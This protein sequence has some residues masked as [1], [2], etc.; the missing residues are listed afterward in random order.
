M[1]ACSDSV[2]NEHDRSIKPWRVLHACETVGSVA[3]LAEAQSAVG[4]IPQMLSREYWAAADA[5]NRFSLMTA[6]NDVRDWRHALNEAEALNS[7]QIVHAHS[8]TSAMAGVRGTLPVVYDFAATLE[9]VAS[10]QPNSGTWL[11]RSLRVAEQFALSRASA[12]V[13][14]CNAMKDVATQRGAAAENIFMI[15]DPI[16]ITTPLPEMT[17]AEEHGIDL[18]RD[19]VMFAAPDV[20]SVTTVLQAFASVAAEVESALLL[21]SLDASAFEPALGIAADLLISD[22]IRCISTEE[23]LKALGCAS[24]VVATPTDNADGRNNAFMMTAMAAGRAIVAA[25]VPENRECS[26]EGRG[27]TW[28]RASDTGDLAQRTTFVAR[29]HD[30]TRTLGLNAREHVLLTRSAAVIGRQ[31]DEVYRF[32]QSRRTENLPKMAVPKIYALGNV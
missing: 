1:S 13:A 24:I 17:W 12:V 29:N 14:H 23:Q 10:R 8:F 28:Y 6:W 31:Y 25:D 27:C 3:A 19:V 32:A 15:P 22:R 5:L 7:V 18:A 9:E 30:F 2:S 20:A 26:I 11:L 16:E 21:L 4:M